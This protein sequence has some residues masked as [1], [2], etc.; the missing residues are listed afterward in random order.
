MSAQ[1]A[2]QEVDRWSGKERTYDHAEQSINY[3]LPT[4]LPASFAIDQT[5][6]VATRIDLDVGLDQGQRSSTQDKV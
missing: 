6:S 5:M 3:T 4:P 1:V 2:E